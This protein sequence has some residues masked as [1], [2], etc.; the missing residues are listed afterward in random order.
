MGIEE[1]FHDVVNLIDGVHRI[2]FAHSGREALSV[3]HF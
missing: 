2:I 3:G 1:L